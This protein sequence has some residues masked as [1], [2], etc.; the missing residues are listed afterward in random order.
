ML[1][2]LKCAQREVWQIRAE[3]LKAHIITKGLQER[4]RQRIKTKLG[5]PTEEE[6]CQG[7]SSR[8]IANELFEENPYDARYLFYEEIQQLI[9]AM[10]ETRLDDLK[11][12][13]L[14]LRQ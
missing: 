6:Q 10:C 12:K 3:I 11:G 13:S 2:S 8:Q 14:V 4:L 7:K 1:G 9:E 5:V